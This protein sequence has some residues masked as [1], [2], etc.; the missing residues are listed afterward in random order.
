MSFNSEIIICPYPFARMEVRATQ[1]IPCCS[2]WLTDEFHALDAGEDIWNGP[3]AQELRGRI[4]NGDYSLCK[5]ELCGVKPTTL[6]RN[7]EYEAQVH[8]SNHHDIRERNTKLSGPPTSLS[9]VADP[10]CNLAC[11]SCRSEHITQLTVVQKKD[12]A[13][14][15]EA[16]RKSASHLQSVTFGDGEATFSPWTR[17]L[18]QSF[19]RESFPQLRCIELKT[20]GLLLDQKCYEALMP[21]AQFIKRVMVSVD[22]GDAHTYKK[23]RGGEWSRLLENL[24]WMSELRAQGRLEKFQINMTLRLDNFL[25]IP[26]LVDLGKHLNVDAV[27]FMSFEPWDRMAI[28]D[29]ESQ[30]VH[31]PQ[32][33]RHD[34]LA[35]IWQSISHE[36]LVRWSL[37][38]PRASVAEMAL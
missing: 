19:S 6:T 15:E 17:K 38:V 33:P 34:E 36:R 12:M 32:H 3:A 1:F 2:G 22:A 5:R 30:A 7:R 28:A 37:P 13:A 23:V 35:E 14:T 25:S 21:G 4:Y 27:K 20:N 11:P 9:V 10:R 24:Q 29:Y 31:L 26:K 16:I 8:S 18:I